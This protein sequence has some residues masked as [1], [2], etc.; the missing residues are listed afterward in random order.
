MLVATPNVKS[1]RLKPTFSANKPPNR[2]FKLPTIL[3]QWIAVRHVLE[4]DD[5]H[6]VSTSQVG[7]HETAEGVELRVEM[8]W[9]LL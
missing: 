2:Y 4:T 7:V 8:S 1:K 9:D 3:L 6:V 5:A